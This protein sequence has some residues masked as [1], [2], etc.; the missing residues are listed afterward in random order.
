MM[1]AISCPLLCSCS[2]NESLDLYE[3]DEIVKQFN[4]AKISTSAH[5]TMLENTYASIVE[6][7]INLQKA[8][9]EDEDELN[10]FVCRFMKSNIPQFG[11]TE[12]L[13]QYKCS[14]HTHQAASPKRVLVQA[15][16]PPEFLG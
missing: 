1:Q 13:I 2:N 14:V 5:N 11:I 15:K 6:S 10:A 7:P 4:E 9:I 12:C 16:H 8:S 3:G